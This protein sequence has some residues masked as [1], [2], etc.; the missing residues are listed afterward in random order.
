MF[1]IRILRLLRGYVIF[2]ASG[3]FFERFL[4]LVSKR[5]ISLWDMETSPEEIRGKVYAKDYKLLALLARQCGV[6]LRVKARFGLPF[7]TY[8]Y[9]KRLGLFIGAAAFVILIVVMQNFVWTLD[10]EG[11]DRNSTER[12]YYVLQ[13]L[14]LRPGAFIPS[15]DIREIENRA[16]LELEHISWFTIN[17]YGSR[18]VVEM[19]ETTDPPEIIDQ[20]AA[21]NVIAS[22]AGVVRRTEVYS[23]K[24]VV[25]VGD[26]VAK[27]DLLVS[28]A[29]DGNPNQVEFKHARAKIFAETYFDET[30]E[31]MKSETSKAKTGNQFDRNYL[32]VFGC[33]IPLF[34]ALP[35]SG[36]YE[37]TVSESPV[38]LFGM[39]LPLSIETLH[40]EEYES[41]QVSYDAESAKA[42][43]EEIN[44]NYKTTQL[45]GIEILSEETEFVELEDRFQLKA[46][47][48]CYENIALE[49]KL[50]Q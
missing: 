31:V 22:K 6:R 42:K 24:Q 43:L 2:E 30:F 4:N 17:N 47:F 8:K 33:K 39:G 45:E 11:N 21:A 15:L 12:V 3:G 13:E 25:E 50:F 20:D 14:G 32:V 40:Y 35:L 37:T 34:I 18:I 41:D 19:K 26:V 9:R 7:L 5:N 16:V 36:E 1:I 10:I 23:G 46:S 28:G 44:E 27:G 38:S 48:I 49:Q 29:L